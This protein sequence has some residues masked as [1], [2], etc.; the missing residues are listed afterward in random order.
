M[1][2]T[3]RREVRAIW[4]RL[5]LNTRVDRGAGTLDFKP[6]CVANLQPLVAVW[7]VE[8]RGAS[9]EAEDLKKFSGAR[10]PRRLSLVYGGG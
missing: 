1:A 5:W 7:R 6:A 8:C 9:A 10:Q 2:V 3:S 4:Q